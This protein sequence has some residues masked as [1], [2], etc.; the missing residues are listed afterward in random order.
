[1]KLI[2]HELDAIVSLSV[3]PFGFIIQLPHERDPIPPAA[4]GKGFL[5]RPQIL[6]PQQR[7]PAP[8]AA[9]GKGLFHQPRIL[10]PQQAR[11]ESQETTTGFKDSKK[12]Q[13]E[14]SDEQLMGLQAQIYLLEER[15]NSEVD[16]KEEELEKEKI[17]LR[18]KYDKDNAD[19]MHRHAKEALDHKKAYKKEVDSLAKE[20]A[21]TIRDMK[22]KHKKEINAMTDRVTKAMQGF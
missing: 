22:A 16:A 8:P 19:M 3:Q 6:P 17:E 7:D 18:Y 5:D 4:T 10:P 12:R 15:H 20:Q 9:N 2:S 11:K 1:M 14:E 21:A 13:K